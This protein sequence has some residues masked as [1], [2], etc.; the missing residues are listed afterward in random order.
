MFSYYETRFKKKKKKETRF[1]TS[2][3]MPVLYVI[4]LL[5]CIYI[6][7]PSFWGDLWTTGSVTERPVGVQELCHY[8]NRGNLEKTGLV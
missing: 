5:Y 2:T 7:F 4:G 1:D 3:F 6:N 8:L